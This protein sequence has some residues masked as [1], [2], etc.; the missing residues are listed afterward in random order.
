MLMLP[1]GAGYTDTQLAQCHVGIDNAPAAAAFRHSTT[2]GLALL[3]RRHSA[4]PTLSTVPYHRGR[5]VT[6]LLLTAELPQPAPTS[7]DCPP[8]RHAASRAPEASRK[9]LHSG[10]AISY[11]AMVAP[12]L[13][14]D[15]HDRTTGI[16]RSRSHAPARSA[17]SPSSSGTLPHRSPLAR[18]VSRG[19]SKNSHSLPRRWT[20]HLAPSAQLFL[21]P[22][23][24][25]NPR[26]RPFARHFLRHE[27]PR[28]GRHHA[29][30]ARRRWPG[31][32]RQLHLGTGATGR[33]VP[34]PVH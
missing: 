21:W 25:R 19:S 10:C 9:R 20:T 16:A 11:L 27:R 6:L 2:T 1:P 34:D 7:R 3:Q 31:Y 15:L 17:T 14:Q 5:A 22:R 8:Q 24:C 12:S 28:L 30:L 23:T 13:P 32:H 18:S 33:G 26:T 29:H 4:P